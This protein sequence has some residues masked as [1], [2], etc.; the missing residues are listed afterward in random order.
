[1]RINE[2]PFF[3]MEG[4]DKEDQEKLAVALLTKAKQ[5]ASELRDSSI[6]RV[7]YHPANTNNNLKTIDCHEISSGYQI[8]V[9][10][11]ELAIAVVEDARYI[12]IDSC[13][14]TCIAL[15][16][17]LDNEATKILHFALMT[18]LLYMH[19]KWDS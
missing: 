19:M 10:G 5:I 3:L 12:K 13:I 8:G 7:L 9:Y 11:G 18:K 4:I 2:K 1:M 16:G 6:L 14:L 15:K 17:G